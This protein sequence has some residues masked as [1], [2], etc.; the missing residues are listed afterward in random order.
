MKR[1][2]FTLVELLVVIAII[3]ILIGMLLPAVQSV[4]E[5]AR[6][7]QCMNNLRQIGLAAH[8]YESAHMG[9]PPI[10]TT[11]GTNP[12][13]I[14]AQAAQVTHT[15]GIL[16][17]FPFMEQN[18]LWTTVDRFAGNTSRDAADTLTDAWG[19]G[20]GTWLFTGISNQQPGLRNIIEGVDVAGLFCPSDEKGDVTTTGWAQ[21]VSDG[22]NFF[23]LNGAYLLSGG[24]DYSQTSY[25]L[26]GGTLLLS[27]SPSDAADNGLWGPFQS[28]RRTAI[29]NIQ[30]GSSNTIMLGESLGLRQTD[31]STGEVSNRRWSL[32]GVTL[33]FARP[34]VFLFAEGNVFGSSNFSYGVMFG[35]NHPGTNSF[36]RCDGSTLSISENVDAFTFGRACGADDGTVLSEF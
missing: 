10:L 19:A 27:R 20:L 2:G 6:R 23:G 32:A 14:S 9:I 25:V 30:D 4:R 15:G 26:N 18:N 8:N 16:H 21:V 7:T 22:G 3:G 34:D 35:S 36:V 11:W 33:S 24:T 12:T 29:E 31:D 28:R 1:R 17:L 5:A 13:D